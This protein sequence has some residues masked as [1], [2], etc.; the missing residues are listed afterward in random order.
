MGWVRRVG[1]RRRAYPGAVMESLCGA[2]GLMTAGPYT[3]LP[4]S[5]LA[6]AGRVVRPIHDV[7]ALQIA[8]GIRSG[9]RIRSPG[10]GSRAETC[11][12]T[13][14][15]EQSGRRARAR[16]APLA[17]V[18]GREDGRRRVS[19]TRLVATRGRHRRP[20][21]PDA[22]TPPHRRRPSRRPSRRPRRAGGRPARAPVRRLRPRSIS[23]SPRRST[24]SSSP[25]TCSTPTP[26]R[27]GR[28]SAS[29]PSSK[30]LVA[31]K[32]RTVIIPGTHDVYDRS[33]LYRVHDLARS[34]ARPP[35]DD[36]SPS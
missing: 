15:P 29:P 23:R 32:I 17:P 35:D 31:A 25:A 14:T 27:G 3:G 21:R 20:A 34:P 30:R 11:A 13:M 2:L 4:E 5:G 16:G 28:S 10:R 6:G 24:S 8:S 22:P 1:S 36:S 9:T 33:S 26:S 7:R 12:V 18:R 19:A